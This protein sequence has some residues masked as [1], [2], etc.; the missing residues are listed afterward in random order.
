MNEMIKRVAL[1]LFA[2]EATALGWKNSWQDVSFETQN[3]YLRNARAAI[4]AMRGPTDEMIVVGYARCWVLQKHPEG[5]EYAIGP[6]PA[7][8]HAKRY[9]DQIQKLPSG[10]TLEVVADQS[11]PPDVRGIVD[12][13]RR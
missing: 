8:H 3:M 7:Q 13:N 9:L 6:F 12:A 5:P 1:E 4:E 10:T 11:L 2:S